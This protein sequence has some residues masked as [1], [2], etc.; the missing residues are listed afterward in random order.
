MSNNH[1]SKDEL[2]AGWDGFDRP[3]DG[4]IYKHYKG[5]AYSV[6]ATGFLEGGE[7]PCVVYKSLIDKNTWVRTAQN[8]FETIEINGK[9]IPR[10]E[11]VE[12]LG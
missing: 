7:T 6:V 9:L 3:K 10:F 4:Q 5:G 12:S 11:P 1:K 2:D 8:F